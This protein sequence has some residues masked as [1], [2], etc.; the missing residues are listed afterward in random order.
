MLSFTTTSKDV[1]QRATRGDQPG[2]PTR[3]LETWKS[4]L[5]DSLLGGLAKGYPKERL[6][7]AY[8][9]KM[10]DTFDCLNRMNTNCDDAD[11]SQRAKAG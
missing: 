10:D 5:E 6:D 8:V 11:Q 3:A 2:N 1:Q 7:G 9:Q 4:G